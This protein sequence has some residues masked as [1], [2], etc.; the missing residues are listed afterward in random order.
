[1]QHGLSRRA[2]ACDADFLFVAQLAFDQSC[3]FAGILAPHVGG[4]ADFGL[5]V[6]DPQ[7][8]RP[9]GPAGDDDAVIARAP[10]RG[11]PVTAG[12]SC[13]NCIGRIVVETDNRQVCGTRC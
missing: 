5:V 10:Q 4:I 9:V 11:G 8:D 3:G 7:I 1:M 6:V 2:D 12:M 13:R